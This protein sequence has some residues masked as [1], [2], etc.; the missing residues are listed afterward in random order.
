MPFCLKCKNHL[1]D[2]DKFCRKCGSINPNFKSVKEGFQSDVIIPDD[3]TMRWGGDL[4]ESSDIPAQNNRGKVSNYSQYPTLRSNWWYLLPIFFF[5][6]GG[7]AAY[8]VLKNDDPSK[9][10]NCLIIGACLSGGALFAIL[11]QTP[12][13]I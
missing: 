11:S 10:K 12:F 5:F 9:A 2:Y 8:F 7:L 4:R 3:K 1:E 13:Y 6:I